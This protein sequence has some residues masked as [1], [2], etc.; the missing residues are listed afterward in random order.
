MFK[1]MQTAQ[2]FEEYKA[3]KNMTG[4]IVSYYGMKVSKVK[5]FC[6]TPWRH[7]G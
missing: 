2:K 7:I 4:D 5:L 3:I 6:Y 1:V